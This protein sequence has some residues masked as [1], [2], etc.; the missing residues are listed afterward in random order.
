[1]T[2]SRR[3]RHAAPELDDKEWEWLCGRTD[4]LRTAAAYL[5]PDE[6]GEAA[7]W[8]EFSKIVLGLWITDWPGTRPPAWWKFDAPRMAPG[9][10][11]AAWLLPEPR[12]R[13]GGIGTAA[14]EVLAVVPAFDRGIPDAWIGRDD[15]W[16]LSR[17]LLDPD[18]A[19]MF[20][21]E[22]A[23]LDRHGL[24]VRSERERLSAEDFAPWRLG[25][26]V[27]VLDD[28]DAEI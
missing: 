6:R 20:E 15:G 7:L 27:P 8:R 2:R 18:D 13:L 10:W 12:Q 28:D 3:P 23:Y 1:M 14:F 4:R 26:P 9:R 21:S 5:A 19:P 17:E 24:F 11:P 22:A 16:Q 25:D